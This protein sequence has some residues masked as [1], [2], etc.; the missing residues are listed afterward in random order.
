[1]VVSYISYYRYVIVCIYLVTSNHIDMLP[2]FFILGRPPW[3]HIILIIGWLSYNPIT[4]DTEKLD[5][6]LLLC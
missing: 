3:S 5:Y 6:V 1:M 2:F 4:E